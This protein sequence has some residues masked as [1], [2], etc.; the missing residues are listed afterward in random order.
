MPGRKG[1]S[2]LTEF[3]ALFLRDEPARIAELARL[4][5]ERQNKEIARQAHMLAGSCAILGA[6]ELQRSA[7]ELQ[8]ATRAGPPRDMAGHISQLKAAWIRLQ[9]ALASQGLLP[10]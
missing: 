10:K 2:L 1:G 7:L 4:V 5:G 9:S 3:I 6:I 8:A